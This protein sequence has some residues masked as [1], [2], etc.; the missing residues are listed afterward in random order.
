[1]K[2]TSDLCAGYLTMRL[3]FSKGAFLM[4]TFAQGETESSKRWDNLRVIQPLGA[5]WVS[6]ASP[7][8]FTLSAGTAGRAWI[9]AHLCSKCKLN[10]TWAHFPIV[11]NE[12]PH[13]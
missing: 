8:A 2:C 9:L 1:M 10:S 11:S 13:E 12:S 6:V 3:F 7:L 5:A 4:C